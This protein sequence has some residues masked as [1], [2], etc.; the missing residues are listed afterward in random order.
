MGCDYFNCRDPIFF[1]IIFVTF[2]AKNASNNNTKTWKNEF[3]E[4]V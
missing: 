2:M 4:Q 1:L 3:D